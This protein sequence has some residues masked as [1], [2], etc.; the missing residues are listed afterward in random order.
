MTTLKKCPCGQTPESLFLHSDGSAKYASA[1]GQCCNEWDVTFRTQ[2]EALDSDKCMEYAID[3]WNDAPRS[4]VETRLRTALHDAI[5]RPMGIIPKSAEGLTT[6]AELETA[7]RLR[8][9]LR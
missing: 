2:Y 9:K 4:D 8:P 5:R 7:E 1:S 6:P 3:A